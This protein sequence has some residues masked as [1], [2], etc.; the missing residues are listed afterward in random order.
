MGIGGTA[1]PGRPEAVVLCGIQGSGKTTF[2]G[3][4]F[5]ATHARIN[6]DELKTRHREREALLTCL[7][8]GRSFVV[9]NTNPT[10]AERAVY[11]QPALAHGFRLVAF[12]I[13]ALPREAI[14]RNAL[15]QGR[16]RIQVPGILGTYKRLEVPSLA[17]GFDAVFRVRSENGERFL[18]E[19][20]EALPDR[21]PSR[22]P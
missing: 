19:P 2:Y 20:L 11:A 8:A 10:A 7:E 16:E 12:W 3:A 15:R 13:E 22:R 4:Q 21:V 18:V 14:V 17:E 9:D 6:L 1:A 5:S